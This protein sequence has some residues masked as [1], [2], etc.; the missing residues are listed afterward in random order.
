MAISRVRNAQSK[1]YIPSSA[2]EN[3]YILAKIKVTDELVE[4]LSQNKQDVQTP[5]L[6]FY[7]SFAKAFFD[8]CSELSIDSC[9][10]VGN[11]KFSRVR[12]SPERMVAQTE[13]Q[14]LFL[15]NPKYH[16]SQNAYFDGSVRAQK[17]T[18][19]FLSNGEDIRSEAASFHQKVRNAIAQLSDKLGILAH[20]FHVF[21][22]QHLTYDLFSK[23]KGITGTITHKLRPIK[24][25]Y[26]ASD[27]AIDDSAEALT[28]VTA[29]FAINKRIKAMFDYT[30]ESKQFE[31]LYS[32]INQ[33]LKESSLKQNV[34]GATIVAN[35]LIPFVRTGDEELAATS[36]ELQ[37]IIA[38]PTKPSQLFTCLF[39]STQLVDKIN[40]VFVASTKDQT[41]H[42]YGKF[43]N[44]IEAVLLSFA[45]RMQF[46]ENK[47]ELIVRFHQH[48][49]F[50]G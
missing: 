39:S 2:R 4:K 1:V 48:I 45:E 34:D 36:G 32:F 46:V 24:T 44:Q 13:Q 47:E 28:Y 40:I 21:D 33:S 6:G 23:S 9:H 12:Y 26:S 10:F 38:S 17:I 37:K 11:D 30:N 41:S 35:D 16:T 43:L 8:V 3:Q 27:V 42:G 20:R 25:R 22:H 14:M 29:D 19:V 15:Y 18:L 49:S 5:Y 7:Q 50:K 31:D